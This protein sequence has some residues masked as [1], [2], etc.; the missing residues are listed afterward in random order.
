MY[1]ETAILTVPWISSARGSA[2][3]ACL[4]QAIGNQKSQAIGNQK[5]K[6]QGILYFYFHNTQNPP[7]DCIE[8]EHY[9]DPTKPPIDAQASGG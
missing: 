2:G 1:G 8:D 9:I 7:S 4:S 5:K 6:K 3:V